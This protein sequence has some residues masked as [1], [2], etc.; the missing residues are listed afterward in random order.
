MG[1]SLWAAGGST[2]ARIER[3]GFQ[4]AAALIPTYQDKTWCDQGHVMRTSAPTCPEC[5]NATAVIASDLLE[6]LH[7]GLIR[8]LDPHLPYQPMHAEQ[9]AAALDGRR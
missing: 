9:L 2:L 5:Q 3:V 8:A 7:L 4:A 6:Q 1:N